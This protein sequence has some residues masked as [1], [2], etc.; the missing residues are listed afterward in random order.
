M[1]RRATADPLRGMPGNLRKLFTSRLQ[2]GEQLLRW[3]ETDLDDR[4]NYDRRVVVLTDRRM[5][6]IA[7]HASDDQ[8]LDSK[9]REW[10]LE[11]DYRLDVTAR[12]GTGTLELSAPGRPLAK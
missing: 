6:E 3:V 2:E 1:S 8:G 4:L 7:T 11:A 5:I 10:L 12:G 9:P